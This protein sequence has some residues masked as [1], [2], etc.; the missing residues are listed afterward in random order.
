MFRNV[1]FLNSDIHN[2]DFQD[3]KPKEKSPYYKTFFCPITSHVAR[4]LEG[5]RSVY[6]FVLAVS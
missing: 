4:C 1:A 2:P 3:P 6:S 5:G